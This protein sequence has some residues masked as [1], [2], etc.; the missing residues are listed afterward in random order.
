MFRNKFSFIL[1][2]LLIVIIGFFVFTNIQ[3]TTPSQPKIS[4]SE[5]E[6]DFGKVKEDEKPAHT[7][8]ITNTGGEE[9]IVSRVRAAC[10]CTATMLS[11][12][13]IL[14]GKKAE[15]K[16][17]FNPVGYEGIIKKSIYIE[18]ND[19]EL[20]KVKIDIIAEVE[21]IP[22]PKAFLS[23]SQWDFGLISQGD[24]PEFTFTVE[25][26]GELE[27]VI[28]KMDTSKY[29]KSNIIVPL[30]IPPTEKKEI[31]FTYDSSEHAIGETKE[32]IRIY[33]NDPRKKAFSLR[34]SGY[35]KEKDEPTVSIFPTVA[36][37]NLASDSEDGS[38][39][40]F[41]LQ[42][43][44][45]KSI[46]VISIS[47]SVDYLIPLRSEI[48]L[49]AKTKENLQLVLLKEKVQNEN[50]EEKKE[51]YLYLTLAIPIEI[52]K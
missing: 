15:L 30:V 10:G 24:F 33:C 7:F 47:T 3:N 31:V 25:N 49:K 1:I 26:K 20:S 19:P 43:L 8:T 42:N 45:E 46:K 21:T 5:E 36:K 40:Q 48:E 38:V 9:L 16:T 29:I 6:W 14:P 13:H 52:I 50:L 27:L 23:N 4:L 32:S 18:S 44:G 17:T 51:N 39:N 34:V 12:D 22:A 37:F 41:T 35:I 11:S 28:E 2:T